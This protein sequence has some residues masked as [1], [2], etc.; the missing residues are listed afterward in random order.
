M[1]RLAGGERPLVELVRS[2]SGKVE[3][4]EVHER[5][6]ATRNHRREP[7]IE[8]A[9]RVMDGVESGHSPGA[10][11]ADDRAEAVDRDWQLRHCL[12]YDTFHLGFRLFIRVD[13]PVLAAD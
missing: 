12:T 8:Q 4:D 2:V 1:V 7:L 9:Q 11:I 3:R 10:R 6:G 13:E 5:A